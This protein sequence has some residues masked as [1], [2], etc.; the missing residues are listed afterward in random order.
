MVKSE[1]RLGILLWFRLSRFY[2]QNIKKT[3]QNLKEAGISTAMF[4][5]IAQIG[6]GNKLTQQELGDKLVVTKGNITQLLVK[7]E[8]LELVKREKVGREKF[9]VLTEKGIACYQE[10][11]PKQEAFQQEQFSRLSRPEQKELLRLLKKLD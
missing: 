1:E 7:L 4:D 5:C 2:N 3:N 11:V 10:F 8:K 6:P 9:I